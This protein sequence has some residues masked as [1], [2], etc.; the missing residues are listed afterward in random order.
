M[1]RFLLYQGPVLRMSSLITEPEHSLIHQSVHASEREEPLNGDGFGV[2][3]YAPELDARPALFR[4]VTPAWNNQNLLQLARVVTSPAILAHV[5]AATQVRSISEANCHPFTCGEYAFMHNGDVGGFSRI[6]RTLLSELSDGAFAT[7]QGGTDSEH[8]FALL[9]EHL[10]A[11]AATVEELVAGVRAT[12]RRLLALVARLAPG[13]PSY[14]NFAVSNG[15]VSVVT[16]FTDHPTY[17][18]ESL[19]LHRGKR[20]VCE[21]GVCRMVSPGTAGTAVIL[22]SESLSGDPGWETVPPNH[23]VAIDGD[24]SVRVEPI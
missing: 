9:L 23:L 14:L 3:W 18:G 8:A 21:D 24:C 22:S 2:A 5:R 13:T 16:R 15:K 19:H 10:P 20:Y 17:P 1:C 12:I 6:R 11:K 7:I 4:S